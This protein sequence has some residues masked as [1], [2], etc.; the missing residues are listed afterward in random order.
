MHSVGDQ[1]AKRGLFAFP[2]HR[3]I[4]GVPRHFSVVG[5]PWL[6]IVPIILRGGSGASFVVAS[7]GGFFPVQGDRLLS[8]FPQVATFRNGVPEE[9]VNRPGDALGSIPSGLGKGAYLCMSRRLHG[10]GVIC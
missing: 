8:A 6:G 4:C 9:G 5:V 10:V 3:A 1:G 7:L 2:M